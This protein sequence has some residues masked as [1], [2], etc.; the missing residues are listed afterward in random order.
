MSQRRSS[1]ATPGRAASTTPI[2]E[3]NSTAASG[4]RELDL[5]LVGHDASLWQALF[6]GQFRLAVRCERCGRWLTAGPSKKRQLGSHCAT[7]V[8]M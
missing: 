4:H 3:T 2:A 1:P 6:D 5:T 7:K 8:V